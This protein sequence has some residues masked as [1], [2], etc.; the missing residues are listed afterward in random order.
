M[1]SSNFY[2]PKFYKILENI[3]RFIK[4][5]TPTG[6]VLYYSDFRKDSGSEAFEQILL[7]NGYEKYDHNRKD[8][9]TLIS[10]GSKRRDIHF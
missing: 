5:D 8:I 3:N 7:D 10:E 2:S 1:E 9:D 6:K 4:D